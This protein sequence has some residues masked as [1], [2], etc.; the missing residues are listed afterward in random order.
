MIRASEETDYQVP[1]E[2]TRVTRLLESI[3]TAYPKLES[4]KVTVENDITK[5]ENF[6]LAADFLCR[7]APKRKENPGGLYRIASTVTDMRSELDGLN[8]VDVDVRYY[9]PEEWSKLSSEQR[10]KCILTR[11]LQ[12]KGGDKL[13]GNKRKLSNQQRITKLNNKWKKKVQKQNRVIAALKADT[14]VDSDRDDN[15]SNATERKSNKKFKFNSG[16]TQRKH[17]DQE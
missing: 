7:F 3:Q 14:K 12:K 10:K 11:Q 8:H 5:R 4:A 16:V 9:K 13:I 17:T 15:D 2:R 1:D 6:E